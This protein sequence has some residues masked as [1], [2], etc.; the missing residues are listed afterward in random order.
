M[1]ENVISMQRVARLFRFYSRGIAIQLSISAAVVVVG[2]LIALWGMSFKSF[3]E[4]P[5]L[6]AYSFGTGLAELPFYCGPLLFAMCRRRWLATAL[7]ATW[8]EK[9]L[10]ALGY[11]LVLVPLFLAAVWYASM[12][13]TSIFTDSANVEAGMKI[14]ITRLM[15]QAE[16]RIDDLWTSSRAFNILTSV[17]TCAAVLWAVEMSRHNRFSMGI[18]ALLATKFMLFVAGLV[19]GIM[20]AMHIVD[21]VVTTEGGQGKIQ[22][23]LILDYAN[24]II[25]WFGAAV[26]LLILVLLG[27]SVYLIKNRQE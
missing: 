4:G 3:L 24:S 10:V 17:F 12:G 15:E 23:D 8:Q 22:A 26:V 27:W 13:V 9:A 16:L 18:V 11:S 14:T 1:N 19:I 21:N 20:A 5:F 25:P 6:P 7:P 2:Y